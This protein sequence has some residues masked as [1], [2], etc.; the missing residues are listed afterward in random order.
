M[1]WG[2]TRRY[3]EQ[4]QMNKG[5]LRF[6]N[7]YYRYNQNQL[8]IHQKYWNNLPTIRREQSEIE[9]LSGVSVK[10]TSSNIQIVP[11][12]FISKSK[13]NTRLITKEEEMLIDTISGLS[14]ASL[15]LDP[16]AFHI[17]PN[18]HCHY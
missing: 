17:C 3:E 14:N 15:T 7:L 8:E 2:V 18:L 16:D 12:S 9:P 5:L 11:L 4:S 13:P 6:E 1:F 10:D